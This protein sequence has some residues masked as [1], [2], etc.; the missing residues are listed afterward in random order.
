MENVKLSM[1]IVKPQKCVNIME[2]KEANKDY[3][4]FNH[5]D[6]NTVNIRVYVVLDKSLGMQNT[7]V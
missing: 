4:K 1:S 3:V 5:S 7:S 2:S 6:I